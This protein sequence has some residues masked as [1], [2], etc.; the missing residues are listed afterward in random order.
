M[1]K[2]TLNTFD[3]AQQQF[4]HVAGLLHPDPLRAHFVV[5]PLVVYSSVLN[6]HLSFSY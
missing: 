1:A 3:M 5:N 6:F 2:E 4:D